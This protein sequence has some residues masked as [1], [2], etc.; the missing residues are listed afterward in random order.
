MVKKTNN[1]RKRLLILGV[2]ILIIIVIV[3]GILLLSKPLN[4]KNEIANPAS[5]Y[6]IEHGGELQII[7]DP[8]GQYGLCVFSDQS[9]CEEWAFMNGTCEEGMYTTEP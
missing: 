1:N 7:D 4:E 5:V 6:C 8:N 2:I 3:V 9:V